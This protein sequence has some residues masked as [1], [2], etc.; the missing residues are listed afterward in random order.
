MRGQMYW[1]NLYNYFIFVSLW[2]NSSYLFAFAGVCVS[3][4]SCL[5]GWTCEHLHTGAYTCLRAYF[6]RLTLITMNSNTSKTTTT[7]EKKKN[8]FISISSGWFP[9]NFSVHV[10]E[11][12]FVNHYTYPASASTCPLPERIYQGV[13][14]VQPS[15]PCTPVPCA[16]SCTR[17]KASPCTWNNAALKEENRWWKPLY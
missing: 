15:P 12:V 17:S 5:S 11:Y 8:R 7:I 2:K 4:C 3:A 14:P 13:V 16:D 6:T 1:L 9:N 10:A